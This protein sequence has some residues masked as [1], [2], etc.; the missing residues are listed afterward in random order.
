MHEL[1]LKMMLLN[2]NI[3]VWA[4][5]YDVILTLSVTSMVNTVVKK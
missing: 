5:Y 2:D 1:K 3:G 4:I